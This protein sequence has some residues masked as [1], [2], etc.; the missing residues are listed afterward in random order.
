MKVPVPDVARQDAMIVKAGVCIY[1]Y[2]ICTCV[3][4]H[5]ASLGLTKGFESPDLDRPSRQLH[6]LA[7][8][9][10]DEA[11]LLLARR[12]TPEELEEGPGTRVRMYMQTLHVGIR[13]TT[14]TVWGG[15]AQQAKNKARVRRT[16]CEV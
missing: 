1:M 6:Q 9:M 14:Q 2:S 8:T 5:I 7:G 13:Q 4:M 12:V 16:G 15:R 3:N 11:G 10:R